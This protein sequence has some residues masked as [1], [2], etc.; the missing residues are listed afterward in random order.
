VAR[1]VVRQDVVTCA[2]EE[3]VG[4]VHE[5]VRASP[6][7]FALVVSEDRCVLGR[8]RAS[9]LE[10]CDPGS[11]AEQV[12][13]AGPSTI[14]LDRELAPLVEQLRERNLRFAIA[15][16]PDGRLVGVL[17]RS[18]AETYLSERWS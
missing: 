15:T 2:L 12:M 14:R 7:G 1:H 3:R 16:D 18:D 6:Y 5:R 8:L 13:E 9:A 4:D 11:T 10:E 17:R